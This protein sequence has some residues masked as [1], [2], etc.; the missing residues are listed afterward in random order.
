[1]ISNLLISQLGI[2]SS[3]DNPSVG[4]MRTVKFLF[5]FWSFQTASDS[6]HILRLHQLRGT[7]VHTS[8]LILVAWFQSN[9]SDAL[10]KQTG[11]Y[12]SVFPIF[13]MTSWS[14]KATSRVLLSLLNSCDIF[15]TYSGPKS[16]DR[17]KILVNA[18]ALLWSCSRNFHNC[19]CVMQA[20]TR[21][22]ND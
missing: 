8:N 19:R 20:C 7:S 14:S 1:M 2:S 10:I 12:F 3:G 16:R 6:S 9:I 5:W 18:I 22:T 21:C 11:I 13:K 4:S 17:G 15:W